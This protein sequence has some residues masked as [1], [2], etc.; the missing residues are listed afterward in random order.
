MQ[1]R[2]SNLRFSLGE[3]VIDSAGK[4]VGASTIARDVTERKRAEEELRR[5]SLY[6]RSL[7]DASLDPLVTISK[8]GKI[9]DVNQATERATGVD[10]KALIGSDFSEYFTDPEKAR[11]G[12]EQ[13][14]ANESVQDYPLAI[15]HT[16]GSVTRRPVQRQ[17]IQK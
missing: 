7:I 10:R 16:S 9:M 11:Q 15:R 2:T 14:F 12:Y 8:D 4:I 13:V 6:A 1:G 3:P 17:R 5:A